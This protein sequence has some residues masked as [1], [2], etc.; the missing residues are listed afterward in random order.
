MLTSAVMVWSSRVGKLK[1]R[2]TLLDGL[3]WRGDENVLDVGCGRG[4]LLIGADSPGARAVA[5]N[6]HSRVQTFGLSDDV[7]W[8]AHDVVAGTASTSRP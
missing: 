5:E 8:Q 2:D 6:A 4:L 3:T 1:L 7:D